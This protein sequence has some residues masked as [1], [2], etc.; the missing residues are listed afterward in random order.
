[1]RLILAFLLTA[2][3]IGPGHS[4]PREAP[5][6]QGV[7]KQRLVLDEA[8]LKSLPT[9]S[10]DVTFETG[11]GRRSGTHVGVLLWL[12]VE[13]AGLADETGKNPGLRCTLIITGRDGYVAALAVGE[14][15]P[16]YER[17]SVIL[18]YEGGEPPAARP[19]LQLVVPGDAHADGML[20]G[21]AP[22]PL[23]SNPFRTTD[24]R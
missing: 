14:I 18:A 10:I 16:H 3:A 15:D 4:E 7:V 23:R 20:R 5:V 17:K 13:K 8:F 9:T 19:A 12:L 21:P 2:L 6:L 1:M 24:R 11:Q 22:S